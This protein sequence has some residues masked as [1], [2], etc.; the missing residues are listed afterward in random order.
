VRSDAAASTATAALFA[1]SLSISAVGAPILILRAGYS[2]TEVGLFI[3]LASL[4]Q[5]A[6]RVRIWALMRLISDKHLVALACLLMSLG[7][8]TLACSADARAIVVSQLLQGAGRGFFWTGI[9]THAV[10]VSSAAAHGLASI[11]LASGLGLVVGPGFAGM[12]LEEAA[13]LAMAAASVAAVLALSAAALL[14]R[15]PLLPAPVEQ[16]RESTRIAARPGVRAASLATAS[17]GAWVG[18]V[19][20]YIPVLLER[21]AHSPAAIGA[22]LAATNAATVIAGWL[23]RFVRRAA[24]G[25]ALALG[26]ALTGFGLAVAGPTAEHLA[27][28]GTALVVSGLAMGLLQTIGPA[29]AAE[30]VAPYERGDAIAAVGLSR[31]SASF[32]APFGVAALL[33]YLP[34]GHALLAAGVLVGLPAAALRRRRRARRP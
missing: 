8:L 5:I 25:S 12:L 23:S 1:L 26:T 29:L 21:A 30:T 2:L 7:A 28:A 15:L 9:Q 33:V 18:L 3:S 34:L 24:F 22:V 27:I 31:S 6:S 16:G 4:A 10:H 32:A 11:N 14:T 20:A 19:G 13:S 17:V